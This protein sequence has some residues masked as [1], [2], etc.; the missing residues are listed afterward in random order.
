MSS[1]GRRG[2]SRET[3]LL[4]A[5]IAVSIAVLLVLSQFRFP[6]TSAEG[7]DVTAVQP[8][9]RLAARAA[10]DDLSLAVRELSARVEGSLLVV[11]LTGG[12]AT[13]EPGRSA[14]PGGPR[15]VPALRVRDDAAVVALTDGTVIDGIVGVPGAAVTVA[16]DP[17]RGLAVVRVPSSSAPVLSIREGVQPLATPGYVV[18]SEASLAGASLRPVF[19]GRSDSLG[20]PRWDTPLFTMGRGAAGDVGAPVFLLDGRLAGVLT[21]T[22]GEPTLI[23][24]QVVLTAVD[25]MLRGGLTTQGDIGVAAQPVDHVLARVTGIRAGA[26]V[27]AVRS[28]GPAAG[29]LS[30]GDVITAVNGQPVRT[31]DAL[32]LRVSRAAPGTTLSLTVAR[33]RGFVTVPVAVR[34]RPSPPGTTS[35]GGSGTSPASAERL[36]GVTF[37]AVPGSGSEVI[38]VQPGSAADAAG[39]VAGDLV[40]SVGPS[41]TPSPGDISKAFDA[42]PTGGAVF[43]SVERE[44]QPR[45]VALQR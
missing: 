32:R 11:R 34:E 23:P 18:V 6:A 14:A 21:S 13:V 20:D 17:I 41:R 42:A 45:L 12:G 2:V 33:N 28:E 7:R 10:F 8:L 5:T 1:P 30:P 44:G 39:L 27:A 37:R 9:A 22:E 16:R 38:R 36:L 3:T 24:A 43:L 25:Q 26:A 31:P 19:V 35:D 40:V 29:V 4:A 15:L